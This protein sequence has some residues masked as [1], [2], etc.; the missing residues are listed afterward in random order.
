MKGIS[1]LFY[2]LKQG[3]KNLRQ[4]G[5]FTL[6]SIGT[7]AACLFLFGIFYFLVSNFQYMM[8]NAETSV[9]VTVFFNEGRTE[10]DIFTI[11]D[12]IM[13]REEIADIIYVSAEEAWLRFQEDTFGDSKEELAETFG[14][15]NPLQDSASLEVYLSDISKQRDLVSFI[16]TIEGV[17]EVKSSDLAAAG[18]SNMNRLVGYVSA[19]IIIILLAVAIF[20]INTTITMGISVRKEEIDRKSVV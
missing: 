18:L 10:E 9:G 5:L 14:N 16:Q 3:A 2:S 15:D 20:L 11:R 8:R 6:A 19:T 17:R 4:N 7:I 1:V 12:Q 13:A